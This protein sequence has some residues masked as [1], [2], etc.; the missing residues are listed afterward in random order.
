MMKKIS[1]LTILAILAIPVIAKASQ[2]ELMV[3]GTGIAESKVRACEI[4][5]DY[6]RRE[7]A[8]IAMTHV[9]STF[10]SVET[11]NG[12]TYKSDQL[13][14]TKA[15]AKLVRK[16]ED[17]SYNGETGMIECAVEAVFKAGFV[18]TNP[19]DELE[20]ENESFTSRD[21]VNVSEFRAGEPFCSKILNGCFREMYSKQL[22][23]FGI[24]AV[25]TIGRNPNSKYMFFNLISTKNPRQNGFEKVGFEVSSRE[26]FESYVSSEFEKATDDCD[27][28]LRTF[29]V[30]SYQWDKDKGFVK[31]RGGFDVMNTQIRNQISLFSSKPKV[32]KEE[33]SALDREME[34]TQGKLDHL[35]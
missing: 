8:Q 4:A 7:A 21:V 32:S 26:K 14:T 19:K 20:I 18:V 11:D 16:S 31:G 9:T 33:I 5:L 30:N 10:E 15:Y 35:F 1:K 6:A 17:T 34:K 24:Q 13:V 29:Y 27:R 25:T 28:C 22:D 12:S 23:K 3:K 2:E